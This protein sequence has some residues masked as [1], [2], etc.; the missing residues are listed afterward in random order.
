MVAYTIMVIITENNLIVGSLVPILNLVTNA[1]N[2]I[3]TVLFERQ[4][5][6]KLAEIIIAK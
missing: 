5:G 6:L 4:I 2:I 1:A 3:A